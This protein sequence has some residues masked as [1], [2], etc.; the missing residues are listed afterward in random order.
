MLHETDDAMLSSFATA[1]LPEEVFNTS[2]QPG[3]KRIATS[4]V[5]AVQVKK[6]RIN[7]DQR[8][9]EAI[10][11]MAKGMND[12]YRHSMMSDDIKSKSVE[13]QIEFYEEKLI[14]ALVRYDELENEKAKDIV[15]GQIQNYQT[16]LDE[17]RAAGTNPDGEEMS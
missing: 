2:L 16:K 3:K 5:M 11:S 4:N 14:K 8:R 1:E 15:N 13:E 7:F 10:E 9:T 12:Y 17:I 6:T